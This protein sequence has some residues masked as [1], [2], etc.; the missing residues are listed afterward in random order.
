MFFKLEKPYLCM[1]V[2]AREGEKM[3][4]WVKKLKE[5]KKNTLA[6]KIW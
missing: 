4:W 5:D 1:C 3:E 2:Y 6:K